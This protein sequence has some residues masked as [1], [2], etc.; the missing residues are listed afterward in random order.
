MIRHLLKIKRAG[1]AIIFGLAFLQAAF[2]PLLTHTVSAA[3]SLSFSW[4]DA[5][6]LTVSGSAS[7][8]LT[9]A[10]PD[11]TR[12]GGSVS[13][14]KCNTMDVTVD[15]ANNRVTLD[16][17]QTS[18]GNPGTIFCYDKTFGVSG[19]QGIQNSRP[20]ATPTGPRV[21][22]AAEKVEKIYLTSNMPPDKSPATVKFTLKDSKGKVIDSRDINKNNSKPDPYNPSV[23]LEVDYEHSYTLEAGKYTICFSAVDKTCHNFTKVKFQND[24]QEYGSSALYKSINVEV[25]VTVYHKAG[26][27]VDVGAENVQLKQNGKVL[28]TATTDKYHHS[29]TSQEQGAPDATVMTVAPLHAT[30][31]NVA[32]GTYQVCL[33]SDPSVCTDVVKQDGAP[34]TPDPV[35]LNGGEVD[36][37]GN[38]KAF[39]CGQDPNSAA[40]KNATDNTPTCESTGTSLSWILCPLINGLSK[41]VDGIYTEFIQPLLKTSPVDL[42]G[43]ANDKS[44]TFEVWSNF[45]VYGDIFLVIGLLVVVFGQS[46]GGGLIDAY[47]A[48]KILPRL[49][50]AAVLINISIYIVAFA[51]DITNI[52]GDSLGNLIT[53]PFVDAK[54]FKL[55]I[56]GTT[57]GIGLVALIGAV[58]Y[59]F[60]NTGPLLQYL[61]VFALIPIFLTFLAIL[62]TV[63]F[64]R[65]L[66][67][68]LVLASPVAFALY[69]LPN[70][71]KYFKKWWELLAK[72]LMVYP[73]IAVIFAVANVL[74]V[75]INQGGHS[76][77]VIDTVGNFLSIIA[78]VVP[79]FLIPFSFKIAG[80]LIGKFADFGGA[81][82]KRAHAAYKGNDR[83][84]F[85]NQNMARRKLQ[86][87][88]LTNREGLINRGIDMQKKGGFLGKTIGSGL[89][90]TVGAGNYEARRSIMNKEEADKV[91]TQVST[92]GDNTVR[93]LF[94][95]KLDYDH[96]TGRKDAN[97]NAIT[98]RR[99]GYFGTG[100]KDIGGFAVG[101]SKSQFAKSEVDKAE[102]LYGQNQSGY[103]GALTYEIGKASDDENLKTIMDVNSA[104]MSK[105]GMESAQGGIWTGAAYNHQQ[106]R[107]ELKHT[108]IQEDGTYKRDAVAFTKE[109]AENVGSYPLS[110]MRTST[111]K[112][113]RE[114]HGKAKAA[115]DASGGTDLKAKEILQY[116]E[117]TARSLDQRRQSNGGFALAGEGD[118][119]QPI[120]GSQSG[121]AGL[122]EQEL[123]GFIKD[124]TGK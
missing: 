96:D 35:V 42:S 87:R 88:N 84:P 117:A 109:I 19:P 68:F 65:G 95:R 18:I 10:T 66:I 122:V 118:A 79:L 1:L 47:T 70:T 86:N 93:A 105:L 3:D 115:F 37:N 15:F 55:Q 28:K 23:I 57:S 9:S 21:E 71:E 52:I 103:Q 108:K 6:T 73:L 89:S 20:A 106:T 13:S 24:S 36:P 48:K 74:S 51:V 112:A 92:G 101:Q 22:T 5:Q 2:L 41:A 72:T 78:L 91:Q 17:P 4:K 46:I 81:M 76:S 120:S 59:G 75:T 31:D 102:A 98:E 27:S 67:I 104:K 114:D 90:R 14:G 43:S 50:I 100:V 64:R 116:T 7:G 38:K 45:R 113:L 119:A 34:S 61:F 30:F 124:V 32:A 110:N 58:V 63:L 8:D 121:A 62:V 29:P 56:N 11:S 69:C 83:D 33:E 111:I 49:L 25:D 123:A 94:A 77:G 44:H 16:S 12:F 80:G 26:Q 82:G 97:G 107:R 60:K 40:C 53:Q 54:D 85:S 39:E 99:S